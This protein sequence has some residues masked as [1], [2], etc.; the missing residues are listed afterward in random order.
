MAGG[1]DRSKQSWW[2]RFHGKKKPKSVSLF[3][4]CSTLTCLLH[5]EWCI[6]GHLLRWCS[7]AFLEAWWLSRMNPLYRGW[8]EEKRAYWVSGFGLLTQNPKF[9]I[10]IY[11]Y[12]SKINYIYFLVCNCYSFIFEM[13]IIKECSIIDQW[14]TCYW[15]SHVGLIFCNIH[16]LKYIILCLGILFLIW[17]ILWIDMNIYHQSGLFILVY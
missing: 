15:V 1:Q 16:Y 6:A 8:W 14:D 10:Y 17:M 12:E 7:L 4:R 2:R 11:R 13:Y 3:G 5:R 9:S